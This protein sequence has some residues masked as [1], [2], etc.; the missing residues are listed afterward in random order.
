MQFLLHFFAKM[1][2]KSEFCHELGDIDGLFIILSTKFLPKNKRSRR[3]LRVCPIY[4]L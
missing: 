1:K 3:M 4:C 2:Q